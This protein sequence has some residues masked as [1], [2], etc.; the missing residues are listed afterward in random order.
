MPISVNWLSIMS[1]IVITYPPRYNYK[2]LHHTVVPIIW[3]TISQYFR[4]CNKAGS[5]ISPSL[6]SSPTWHVRSDTWHV[7]SIWR[8]EAGPGQ[9]SYL[10]LASILISSPRP[11]T[12]TAFI[13]RLQQWPY[14]QHS[15]F[16][17][18]LAVMANFRLGLTILELRHHLC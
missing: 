12:T 11:A 17:V 9:P 4:Y 3:P 2:E 14:P 10:V 15:T 18:P 13:G 1:S 5:V 6:A 7:R 8:A 16:T